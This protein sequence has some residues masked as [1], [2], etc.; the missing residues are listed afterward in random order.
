MGLAGTRVT[1]K[2][3]ISL[4]GNKVTGKTIINSA[5]IDR[6]LKRKIKVLDVFMGRQFGSG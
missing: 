4:L 5:F 3:N 6:R 1:D 2:D